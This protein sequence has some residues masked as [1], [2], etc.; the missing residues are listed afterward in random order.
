MM[1]NEFLVIFVVSIF[2]PLFDPT[3]PFEGIP[4][5][6]AHLDPMPPHK[7][8]PVDAIL[9]QPASP[10]SSESDPP[11]MSASSSSSSSAL[12]DGYAPSD[13]RSAGLMVNEFLS[14]RF[15]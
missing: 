15:V 1:K 6:M 12:D 11:K 8:Q 2:S 9:P 14:S 13:P 5:Y 7:A 3:A 10:K 4:L